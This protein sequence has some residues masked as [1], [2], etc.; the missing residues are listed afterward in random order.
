MA[1]SISLGVNVCSVCRTR[2]CVRLGG[3]GFSAFFRT[4]TQ[5]LKETRILVCMGMQFNPDVSKPGQSLISK[6]WSWMRTRPWPWYTDPTLLRLECDPHVQIYA[7]D[8]LTLLTFRSIFPG[9]HWGWCIYLFADTLIW[10]VHSSTSSSHPLVCLRAPHALALKGNVFSSPVCRCVTIIIIK[11]PSES[12]DATLHDV[13][14]DLLRVVTINKHSWA[15]RV[16]VYTVGGLNAKCVA[17][18]VLKAL[19]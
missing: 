7:L 12:L 10:A 8:S 13:K 9:I 17:V 6:H 3:A 19:A 15:Y 14:N 11:K 2:I 4:V 5:E 1:H 18:L 16:S